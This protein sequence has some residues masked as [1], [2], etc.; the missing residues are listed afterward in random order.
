MKTLL[1][2]RLDARRRVGMWRLRIPTLPAPPRLYVI[3]GATLAAVAVTVFVG[4][5]AAGATLPTNLDPDRIAAV[6]LAAVVVLAIAQAAGAMSVDEA[7]GVVADPDVDLI[8]RL[9]VAT[10]SVF[11][12]RLLLAQAVPSGAFFLTVVVPVI[13]AFIVVTGAVVITLQ[14]MMLGLVMVATARCVGRAACLGW[15]RLLLRTPA[16]W[17]GPIQLALA[18]GN[19]LLVALLIVVLARRV[20]S[21]VPGDWFR[22]SEAVRGTGGGDP[23]WGRSLEA[24][25]SVLAHPAWTALAVLGLLCLA[26][27]G[28]V[29][30]CRLSE[31]VVLTE[32]RTALNAGYPWRLNRPFSAK[33]ARA[34]TDK[35]L[36]L[37]VRRGPA[38]WS[39]LAGT[40]GLLPGIALIGVAASSLPS[41]TPGIGAAGQETVGVLSLAVPL[42]GFMAVASDSLSALANTDAEGPVLDVIK[43]RRPIFLRFL[44]VRATRQA[45]LTFS[46]ALASIGLIAIGAAGALSPRSVLALA[47]LSAAVALL[48][49]VAVVVT[50][51]LFPAVVRPTIGLAAPEPQVR[52]AT[53]I[54]MFAACT[55][56]GPLALFGPMLPFPSGLPGAALVAA[57]ATG[58]LLAV[59]PI[60]GRLAGVTY[61]RMR[62]QPRIVRLA[63]PGKGMPPRRDTR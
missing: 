48:D 17:R 51:A 27:L 22:K 2:W 44:A 12:A 41:L 5:V 11:V 50:S 28:V 54:S 42:T 35:D 52:A 15:L 56:A 31:P 20:V 23:R 55:I 47:V 43:A 58:L 1:V 6:V 37:L 24:A 9:P 57:L 62:G 49:A 26:G 10:S 45:R 13:A 39:F 38:V 46:L 30:L 63:R 14:V 7:V 32:A 40:V 36:R 4:T 8:Q 21:G 25:S 16:R 3:T 34:V 53:G 61:D 59:G 19:P 60:A 33:V 29:L 18:V